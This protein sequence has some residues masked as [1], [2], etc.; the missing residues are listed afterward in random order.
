[1]HFLCLGTVLL[2]AAR[3]WDR[4]APLPA[5]VSDEELLYQAAIDAGVDR[6]DPATIGRLARLGSFVGEDRGDEEAL[7][8][9]ARRLGLAR[10]DVVVRRHLAHMMA[11]AAG[12]LGRDEIPTDAELA[13]RTAELTTPA[14]VRFTQVYVSRSRH[15]ARTDADAAT[16]LDALR[17]EHVG[18]EGAAARG[19]AFVTGAD[20]GPIDDVD[21]D[22]RFGPGFAAALADAPAGA[23]SGPL[24]STYGLHLVWVRER[25]APETP[26]LDAVRGQ[27]T[28]RWL[29]ERSAVRAQERLAALRAR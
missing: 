24:R 27:L 6:T 22:R 17:A 28:H 29:Q 26:A 13:A 20:V 4:P 11:L 3:A 10:S 19:D 16:L 25:L 5:D 23:W 14:R 1:V 9:E 15:G 12:R 21:L 7:A 2:V 18:P 8:A